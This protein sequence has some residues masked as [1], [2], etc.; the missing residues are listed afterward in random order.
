MDV[1]YVKKRERE[2]E[3]KRVGRY[4]DGRFDL[5]YNYEV[6]LPPHLASGMMAQLSIEDGFFFSRTGIC[7]EMGLL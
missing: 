6:P 1:H 5:I 2:R 7:Y 3:S 4:K